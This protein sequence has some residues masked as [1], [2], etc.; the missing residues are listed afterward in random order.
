MMFFR[1]ELDGSSYQELNIKNHPQA[2]FS[3]LFLLINMLICN[4]Y[5]IN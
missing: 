1:N 3:F 5:R 4:I 2:V